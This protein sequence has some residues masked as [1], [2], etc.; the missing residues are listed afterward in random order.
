MI[1]STQWPGQILFTGL[2]NDILTG[3]CLRE[4]NEENP[5]RVAYKLFLG[6]KPAR[7]S[8]DPIAVLYSVRP[9]LAFWKLHQEGKN[10]I[11]ENG[12]NEWRDGVAA[13]H[14]LLQ[15]EEDSKQKLESMLE[16][17]MC[18]VRE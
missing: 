6:D 7:P 3:E 13:N 11:F 17:L 9:E 12:T 16:E 15:L 18:V 1:T 4:L 14:V 2:G 10:H 5:A 8:W